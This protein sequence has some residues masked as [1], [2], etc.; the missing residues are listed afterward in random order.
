MKCKVLLFS[1]RDIGIKGTI[2]E[3]CEPHICNE[4]CSFFLHNNKKELDELKMRNMSN[5]S[6]NCA[7]QEFSAK[8]IFDR[9]KD[10]LGSSP[11]TITLAYKNG[12]DTLVKALEDLIKGNPKEELSQ[13]LSA[14]HQGVIPFENKDFKINSLLEAPAINLDKSGKKL[15]DRINIYK[16]KEEKKDD[17][18][19]QVCAVWPLIQAVDDSSWEE[20]LVKAVMETN[21]KNNIDELEIYLF[22][23]DMDRKDYFHT[24]FKTIYTQ[25]E[26]VTEKED[27]KVYY[28][29]TSFT[30]ADTEYSKIKLSNKESLSN[31]FSEIEKLTNDNVIFH[32]LLDL[33]DQLAHWHEEPNKRLF[34]SELIEFLPKDE[35]DK[36]ERWKKMRNSTYDMIRFDNW[37]D[38][39]KQKAL[40]NANE[41]I[42]DM[43]NYLRGNRK[44]GQDE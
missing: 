19:Y 11:S 1:T 3:V 22:L 14:V 32:K 43:I 36:A 25:K 38:I 18:I 37:K 8:Y 12:K 6:E 4:M 27:L 2:F 41:A 5:E 39:D 21:K 31:L 33:S 34:A 10:I 15:E 30:H 28:T 17:V 26:Y 24:P 23:H 13:L 7:S 9:I 16:T 42:N 29:T 40:Q 20:T 35:W 44:E